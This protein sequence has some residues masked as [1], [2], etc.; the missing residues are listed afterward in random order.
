MAHSTTEDVRASI[1]VD[2]LDQEQK[3]L[4]VLSFRGEEGISRLFRFELE[5]ASSSANIAFEDTLGRPALL[6]LQRKGAR[7]YVHGMI[8]HF[9]QHEKG[10]ELTIYHATLVSAVWQLVLRRDCRIFQK[11]PI[12]AKQKAG[13]AIINK[14]LQ[15]MNIEFEVVAFSGGNKLAEDEEDADTMNNKQQV[16]QLMALLAHTHV[17]AEVE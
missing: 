15:G 2:G 9:E 11:V 4:H 6:T 5:L 12:L 14:V 8:S 10:D 1:A 13:S 7:R 17:P 16:N 3:K